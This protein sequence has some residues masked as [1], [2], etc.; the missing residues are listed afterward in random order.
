MDTL[1]G[2][3]RRAA[4]PDRPFSYTLSAA[5]AQLLDRQLASLTADLAQAQQEL[6]LAREE[7]LLADSEFRLAEQARDEAQGYVREHDRAWREVRAGLEPDAYQDGSFDLHHAI[8][9]RIHEISR[10]ALLEAAE[11]ALVEFKHWSDDADEI[12]AW[13]TARAGG[14]P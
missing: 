14:Q 5:D 9:H 8:R 2:N 1:L 12:A 3:I 4:K 10:T 13:L 11:A 6:L 7:K